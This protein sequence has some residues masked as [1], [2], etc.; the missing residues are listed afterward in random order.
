MTG[1]TR[2]IAVVGPTASGKTA[3]AVELALRLGGEIIS[4]DSMQIYKGMNI[5]TAKV[6]PEET[7]GIP[8]HLIDIVYPTDGFSCTDYAALAKEKITEISSRGKLPVFCGGTGLYLDSA[9]NISGF[10]DAGKDELFRSEMSNKTPEQLY[11]TLKCTDPVSAEKI[12]RNNVKR[13]IRALEIY[14]ITGKTKSEWDRE[15]EAANPPY[16]SVIIGLDYKNRQTLYQRINQRVELMLRNGLEAEVKSLDSP[17]F[18]ESQAAEAIGYK[19]MLAYFDGRLS[20][21]EAEEEI[22]KAS[23]NYAKR[24]LTWFRKNKTV[25]WIYADCPDSLVKDNGGNFKF[26]VNSALNII[27]NY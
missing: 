17:E 10:S 2:V 19:E 18:R 4:C 12:H 14:H 11:E 1:K 7:R 25:R 15:S 22:K 21:T 16:D 6:T 5:G 23:R 9:L 24:Q 13:V 27:N 8:H 3:L 20:L 26:I